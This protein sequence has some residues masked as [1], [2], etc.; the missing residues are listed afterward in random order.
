MC[1]QFH[2]AHKLSIVVLRPDYIVDRQRVMLGAGGGRWQPGWVC[3]HDLAE[4][5]RLALETA[6]VDFDI[7]HIVGTPEADGAC[8]AARAREVLGLQYRGNLEQYR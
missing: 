4:A 5:S 7:F 8:E 2:E 3:R 6:A 1:R